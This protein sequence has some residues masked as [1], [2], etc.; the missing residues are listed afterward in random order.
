MKLP[1]VND[2]IALVRA[3]S[4]L[5]FLYNRYDRYYLLYNMYSLIALSLWQ[6]LQVSRV[7]KQKYPY[8][9]H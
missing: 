6:K 7:E 8:F 5:C 4:N 2:L 9:K 3:N 1:F